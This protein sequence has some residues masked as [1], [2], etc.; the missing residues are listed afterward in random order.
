MSF[1]T[2]LMHI[3]NG[4]SNPFFYKTK[5]EVENRAETEKNTE[6]WEKTERKQKVTFF[7]SDAF[8]MCSNP[9]QMGLLTILGQPKIKNVSLMVTLLWKLRK[10]NQWIIKEPKQRLHTQTK[11]KNKAKN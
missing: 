4:Q 3:S 10:Q 5:K 1:Y 7:N 11:T 2:K 8:L 9:F 6:I